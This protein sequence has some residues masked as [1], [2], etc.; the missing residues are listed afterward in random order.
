MFLAGLGREGVEGQEEEVLTQ[1]PGLPGGEN[2]GHFLLDK[3][4]VQRD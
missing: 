1:N 3:A 4:T 2:P